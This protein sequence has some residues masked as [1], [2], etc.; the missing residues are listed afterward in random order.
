MSGLVKVPV[1]VGQKPT[2]RVPCL[3]TSAAGILDKAQG[4][5]RRIANVF[6]QLAPPEACAPPA[7]R[8]PPTSRLRGQSCRGAGT[9]RR[10]S[11]KVRR[12]EGQDA[13]AHELVADR[14]RKIG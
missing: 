10:C 9:C 1:V 13:V 11:E 7:L 8:G 5:S 4:V 12:A 6:T 3:D 2:R 14:A